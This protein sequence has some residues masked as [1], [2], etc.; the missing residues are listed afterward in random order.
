MSKTQALRQ[1]LADGRWHDM[2]AMQEAGGFR[3]GG[4]LLEIRRGEDGL[5]ALEVEARGKA[6]AWEYRAKH[7]T[8]RVADDSPLPGHSGPVMS[9]G[10]SFVGE[11][12]YRD[13]SPRGV[14]RGSQRP[15]SLEPAGTGA[16]VHSARAATP[17]EGPRPAMSPGLGGALFLDF[18]CPCGRQSA[19]RQCECGVV[20]CSAEGHVKH[21]CGGAP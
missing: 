7:P 14:P 3:Y 16:G 21:E 8:L 13:E 18:R 19:A 20:W 15:L 1:L 12:R 2:R 10:P 6:N 9:A 11:R 5:P 4:R 17:V